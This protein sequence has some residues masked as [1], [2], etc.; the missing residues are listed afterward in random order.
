ME[1][2]YPLT[3][4]QLG[5]LFHSEYSPESAVYHN[6]SSLRIW[7][8][9][10]VRKF[11]MALQRLA[12]RHSVLRTSFDLVSFS[13]PLQLVHKKIHLPLQVEDLQHISPSEQEQILD[14][15]FES[16]KERKFDW[17]SPPLLRFQI[18]RCHNEV[19][20]LTWA[21]HHTILDGWSAASMIT[22]LF[23]IYF[24]LL[25]EVVPPLPS[26]PKTSFRDF[27]ALE[28]EALESQACRDFW[29]GKV[30]DSGRTILPRWPARQKTKSARQVSI[31]EVP[32]PSDVSDRLRQLA[33]IAG[34]PLKS[35]LLAAHIRVLSLLTGEQSVVSGLVTNVRPEETD[36]ERVLGLFLN[37]VPFCMQLQGG[38]WLDLVRDTFSAEQEL[39]PFQRYPL[40]ELQKV[41][42]VPSL[43]ET[44]FIFA[45]FHVYHDL[46]FSERIQFLG[47]RFFEETNFTFTAIF[48]Q[49]VPASPIKLN[50]HYDSSALS[51]E[52]I[53]AIGNYYS[54]VLAAMSSGPTERYDHHS[55]LTD[56]E[57][58]RLLVEWND[59]Q[60]Q[61]PH[62]ACIHQL[63]E[64]QEEQTPQ[65][66]AFLCEDE[67]LTYRELNRRANQLAHYLH[68]L[69][70]RSGSVVG[71]HV[72]RSP[73]MLVALLGVLKA[74]G[75]Y[76]PLDPAYPEQ[77]LT[78]MI[79]DAQTSILLTQQHLPR[80]VLPG[81][82]PRLIYLDQ[83]WRMIEQQSAE[84]PPFSAG[85]DD[86]AYLIYTS[87]STGL[88]KAVQI[89]H[90]ALTNLLCSM[91]HHLRLTPEDVLL[92]VTTLSFD[93]AALELYLPL[94]T[95]A[96]LTLLT[97]AAATDGE[98]LAEAIERYGVS[99]MQAT[100]VTWR[101]LL[102][103]G[104]SGQKT[105]KALCGGDALSS[106][107]AS[108]LLKNVGTLW[109][110][111]GP[112]ETTI[113][114]TLR[115]VTFE[116]QTITIG[117]PIANTQLYV[118]DKHFQPVPVGVT[119]TLY[120]GGAGLAQGYWNQPALTA[121]KF[122]PNPFDSNA[123]MY[124]TGDL[125]RYLPDGQLECLGRI[126]HQVKIRGF[127]IELGEI[128][129]VLRQHPAVNESVV[130]AREDGPQFTKH[131]VAYV[132]PEQQQGP[133]VSDLRQFLRERL[134]DY[135]LPTAFVVV[136]RLPLTPAGKIDRNALPSPG[137]ARPELAT[138]YESPR[139]FVEQTLADLWSQVLG[140]QQVGIHDNFFDL[141]GDSILS[142]Q[143]ITRAKQFG[144]R[145][146]PRQVFEQQSIARL[147]ILIESTQQQAHETDIGPVP[148]L[149][150]QTD[151]PLARLDQTSLDQLT[152][153]HRQIE[154]IYALS[155]TQEGLLFHELYA[156]GLSSYTAQL[157]C[158][159][160]GPLDVLT[161][162]RA[163]QQMLDRHP[164]LRTKFV[165]NDL[166]VPLQIV[167]KRVELPWQQ[168]DWRELSASD[169]EE[170][171]KTFLQADRRRGFDLSQ[172]PLLRLTLVQVAE[173]TYQLIL[174]L[175][176]LILD[177][178]SIALVMKEV[179]ACYKALC[180]REPV[181]LQPTRPYSDY[182][183]WLQRQDL[184]RPEL[185][186]RETMKDFTEPTS[187]QIDRKAS[188]PALQSLEHGQQQ[189]KLTPELTTTLEKLGRV[190]RL[191]LNTILQGAWALLLSRYSGKDDVLFGATVSGRPAE[192]AGV[193]TMV[194][195]FINTL[196]VRVKIPAGERCA[197]WLRTLQ[198]QQLE[199]QQYEYS[200]LVD[201][202]AWSE[203]SRGQPLFETL[204]VFENFPVDA[205]LRQQNSLVQVDSVRAF[206]QTN[207]P[208][209]L[210]VAP[211]TELLLTI[212]YDRERFDD[213]TIH[214]LLGHLVTLLENMAG[215]PEQRVS[216]VSL[217]T[218]TERQQMLV[219][220]NDTDAVYPEFAGIHQWIEAQA[221]RGSDSIAIVFEDHHI[222]Y[223]I[224][225]EHANRVAAYLRTVGVGPEVLV[226]I[227][228]ER[229]PEM[230]VGILS[231]LK[232]GGAY[233]PLD[234]ADSPGRLG[235]ILADSQVQIIL[236]QAHLVPTLP[237]HTAQVISLDSDWEMMALFSPTN[238]KNEVHADNL[239]YVIYTSGSTG[240][241]KGVEVQHRSLISFAATAQR[242]YGLMRTDR[243]LQ[244]AS[245]SFD[246]SVEEIFSCLVS[247]AT[248]V[249]RPRSMLN[250]VGMFI[251]QCQDLALTVLDFPTA[252]WHA[253]V[254]NLE[255]VSSGFPSSLR[256]VI[257]GGE[258]ASAERLVQWHNWQL[259][260]GKHVQFL[261]TYGP[262]EAT[263]TTTMCELLEPASA[264]TRVREVPIGRPMQ[265]VQTYVLDQHLNPVGIGVPGELCIGGVGVTRGYHHRPELAADRFI[266]NSFSNQPGTRLYR[267]G[268]RVCYLPDG[269]LVFLGRVDH[270]VKI[271]G[272]R[273]ELGEIE[274]ALCQHPVVREAVVIARTE[275]PRDSSL[276]VAQNENKRLVAYFVSDSEPTANE[277]LNFLKE[278][279]PSYMLPSV[280]VQLRDLPHTA[281]GKIDRRALP[282]PEPIR[283]ELDVSFVPPR[284][285]VEEI[286]VT[287]WVQVLGVEQVG[288]FD[289][290]FVLG[291]HSLLAIQIISRVNH[292]FGIDLPLADFF[293]T[294]TVAELARS[295]ETLRQQTRGL[296]ALP[297]VPVAQDGHGIPLSLNQQKLW[298]FN[299]SNLGTAFF[300]TP[301]AVHLE[302]TLNI[303]AL[304]RA[305]NEIVGRHEILRTIYLVEDRRPVQV[306]I[307]ALKFPV[308]IADLQEL[309]EGEREIAAVRIAEQ[310]AKRPFD[311]AQHLSLRVTLLQ[312]TK[313][314]FVLLMTMHH[315]ASDGWSFGILIHE[316]I[317]LYSAFSTGT[318]PSLPELP[319]QYADY[320][321][322]QHSWLQT[323]TMKTQL[324]YWK[325]KL[326]GPLPLMKFLPDQS[327]SRSQVIAYSQQSLVLPRSLYTA[328]KT[329][330]YQE[331]AT[332]FIGLLTS[333]KVLLNRV[334]RQDDIR[335]G[336]LV[337][338]RNRTETEPLIGFFLNTLVLRTDLS[339]D[340]DVREALRRVR[341][342]T[343]EAYAHQ[344]LPFDN[345]MK[346]L[347]SDYDLNQT[348]LFQVLFIF[349]NAPSLSFQL[350]GVTTKPFLA[351]S[352]GAKI[353][354]AL[355]TFDLIVEI[356]EFESG[357]SV[358]C[359]YNSDLYDEAIINRL[360]TDFN[361]V[362]EA[363]VSDPDQHL[364]AIDVHPL[365]DGLKNEDKPASHLTSYSGGSF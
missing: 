101:L 61:Y 125:A 44:L 361:R 247:G 364:S 210:E 63:F 241:P 301:A 354:Q 339:G 54:R 308:P 95:G 127:R 9:L 221:E 295:V 67:Q 230:F 164:A 270:Q 169:Q 355:S 258:W 275:E 28:R 291:G 104:W 167:C 217:L 216:E 273:V 220:W 81:L 42:K 45:H 315:I 252:Y 153:A 156:P 334:T 155:P 290:F 146:T 56:Q 250:S 73:E 345:L 131:L 243:V 322:W 182:I 8:P 240:T 283:S 36:I 242:A 57:R 141:G 142:L 88:P 102:E 359:R 76:L 360:M 168:F 21:Q 97:Q 321:Y 277:L 30:R 161:F 2:A 116:D 12:A 19:F 183:R 239:A 65:T 181:L 173:E 176:H 253:L 363:V 356:E 179:L 255:S 292:T 227:C 74:G 126:D 90:R 143:I 123:R 312:L 302:G 338:N 177:G 89:S 75:T 38:C 233:V 278:R 13:E 194:G 35:V 158:T 188:R 208:L 5:M 298:F 86:L 218:P 261:N 91:Q 226:G 198:T 109:N 27:V 207:Y 285:P 257:I 254:A 288:I 195:L 325:E 327:R 296:H 305:F 157:C 344:D 103:S 235:F 263:V 225:N 150:S 191:T 3:R 78:Y 330:G 346:E 185:F 357:L 1:D 66:I 85:S 306:V 166:N 55:P 324:A 276:A 232:A 15:W 201:V 187:L 326:K 347:Q 122:L 120:I 343:L 11:Q 53:E 17:T 303:E 244:F 108:E 268:D 93:I 46:P 309:P 192:L 139:T 212:S 274:A 129:A 33:Q 340:P 152:V 205:S 114:S 94:M 48:Q 117:R 337:A 246:A 286:L 199:R 332:P 219:E 138:R 148:L 163:W 147:A 282:A 111:Y 70:I 348:P 68:R 211:G 329:M 92:S 320:A 170:Q 189:H 264:D 18:H 59:T 237:V 51:D 29:I 352:A 203:I 260:A 119:G 228:M 269:N 317:N 43:F 297:L 267:T 121:A 311:L 193:E 80:P 149:P 341:K 331:N 71:I 37:T 25:G 113:W 64:A 23:K 112:T 186:W 200:R 69:G 353:Q 248:L 49:E 184:S 159:L 215:N 362:L 294:P 39:L 319:V 206:G 234:P 106:D 300:N 279:L 50:L 47:A 165:W 58:F 231:I 197:A 40:S 262:T 96:R 34:V 83:D 175:N 31:R 249:L 115:Q 10:D 7:A 60:A 144:F 336:T 307:P 16:E 323:E 222:S 335:V 99:V 4:L 77:R 118:L 20:H 82:G 350:P 140:L 24:T 349:Q 84:N 196:P 358:I 281:S 128:E 100:P 316:L 160:R 130:V 52:Q 110:V 132:V 299:Q 154:D 72:E 245:I 124:C 351:R 137:P 79:E 314:E 287:I 174:K 310:E 6:V 266:P 134:P 171:L 22:E 304:Q 328:L 223:G 202:Q 107:L 172:S 236:T 224:L 229:S 135:M 105:L 259:K 32:L 318:T 145:L 26:V 313:N 293:S 136:D 238:L 180:L 151:F 365:D 133:T 251:Q 280:F 271:R 256:L 178:W 265:N 209:T 342:T 289:N 272:F 284:T 87:G 162:R 214:R 333:F 204:L 62:D 14:M 98:Q 213:A 190:E 41:L